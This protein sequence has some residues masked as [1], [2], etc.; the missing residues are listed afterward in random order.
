MSKLSI[1]TTAIEIFMHPSQKNGF[2]FLRKNQPYNANS[3]RFTAD[4]MVSKGKT[5]FIKNKKACKENKKTC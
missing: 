5:T 4:N 1:T 2:S 3:T